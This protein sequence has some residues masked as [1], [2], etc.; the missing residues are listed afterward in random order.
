[1]SDM[2]RQY[3]DHFSILWSEV[4]GN[5]LLIASGNPGK[6]REI[7]AI[8]SMV[9][10]E[11]ISPV[12]KSLVLEVA[13]TGNSYEENA[14]IKASAY[15]DAAGM[16]VLADDS[17]LEVDALNGAPGLYSNRFSPKQNAND[18]DRRTYLLQQ[19]RDKPGPWTAHFH[20]TA[21]LALPSGKFHSTTGR[22]DGVIIPEERGE[23]GFGYDPIFYIPEYEATMAQLPM[24]LKNEIS[25]RGK[26]LSAMIPKIKEIL[27]SG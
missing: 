18:A 22:C 17:G 25:H 5:R 23:G 12:E 16:P 6:V 20:C 9:D 24:A 27:A 10:I 13:E 3:L 15:L 7:K 4:M 14:R 2:V 11:L 26:A 8:L 21:V 19:L 1:M